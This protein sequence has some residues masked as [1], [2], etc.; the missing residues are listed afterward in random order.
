MV[1]T[2]ILVEMS[3]NVYENPPQDIK[4]WKIFKD[5]DNDGHNNNK[6]PHVYIQSVKK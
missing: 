1:E 3:K 5:N 2:D 4:D 6:L